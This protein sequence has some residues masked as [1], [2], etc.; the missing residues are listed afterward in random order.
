MAGLVTGDSIVTPDAKLTGAGVN[1]I[2][3]RVT[4]VDP[5]GKKVL[6]SGGKELAYDKLVLGMGSSPIMLPIPG[7]DLDGVFMLRSLRHA[8]N[9]RRFLSNRKPRR[10]VFIGAG[11]VSLEMAVML[12]QTDPDYEITVIECLSYP[13]PTM[14]DPE[15][16]DRVGNSLED[17]GVELKMGARVVEILGQNGAVSGVKLDSGEI[18]D[19]EM[20][21]MNV[22]ARPNVDLAVDAGLDMGQYGIKVNQFLETSDPDIMAAGDC[23]N[24]MHFVTGRPNSGAL[25]GPAVIMGRLVAKRLA[26]YEIPFPGILN[27]CVCSLIDLNVAAT[28]LNEQQAK[29]EGFEPVSATVDSRSKHGMIP[30]MK[31]W[32]LKLVFDKSSRKLIGGQIVSD[33][34]PPVK[35]I[36]AISAL[37]LGGKTVED[38]T[39]FM[40]AGNPDCS[41]EPSMEPIAI[42]G[43]QALQKFRN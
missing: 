40:A 2:I 33:A 29:E 15:L 21:F 19:A 31:P 13:L 28:G 14:L 6:L 4:K 9:M 22:G 25:R 27:A 16:K 39:V 30:N 11:F 43:E 24:N 12:K 23:T 8:E 37:I 20:L 32:T 35:E 41:P 38:L 42:A 10:L 1:A 17:R 3:D 26:G 36:D 5:K 7:N 34:M 18:I